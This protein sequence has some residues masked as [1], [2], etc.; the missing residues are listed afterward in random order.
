MRLRGAARLRERKA[1]SSNGSSRRRAISKCRSPATASRSSRSA[2]AIARCSV[3][4]RNGSRSRRPRCPEALRAAL[5]AAALTLARGF[6]NLGTFEFLVDDAGG[7]LLHRGQSAAA[8]RARRHRGDDRPRSRAPAIRARR[9][10]EAR[11][12][13]ARRRRR[14][15]AA[16]RSNGAS[17]P[18]A[19][20]GSLAFAP[21]P[22]R[23]CA[24][25]SASQRA[26]RSR[27]AYDPLLA[28]LIVRGADLAD[29]AR[30]SRRALAEWEIE[31]APTN[32]DRLRALAD[33]DFAEANVR[34]RLS[35]PPHRRPRRQRRAPEP[36][37]SAR[38]S[39]AG[40][41]KSPDAGP[42]RRG[43]DASPC[44]RR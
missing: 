14:R 39:R 16:R 22:A 31:G 1:C 25:T 23:A 7:V 21:P 35:R 26:R 5:D 40:S 2:S 30:R 37:R 38:R 18:R 33:D 36:A 27:S 28:K 20:A 4:I 9:R 6:C 8:S 12:P 32:L 10:R 17:S 29:A 19:A 15:R 3:A 44:S 41:S 13:R 43:R 42:D 34:R 11:R 24:S